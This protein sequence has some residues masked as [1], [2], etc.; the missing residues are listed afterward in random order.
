MSVFAWGGGGG[1]TSMSVWLC[2][3]PVIV[4]LVNGPLP[5]EVLAATLTS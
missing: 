3:L 1:G 5:T 4:T 2:D